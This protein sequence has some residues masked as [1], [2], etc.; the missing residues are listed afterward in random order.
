M[1]LDQHLTPRTITMITTYGCTA[2]CRQCCFESSPR[3]KGRL[4]LEEMKQ[5]ISDAK[6]SFTSL[7]VAVFSGGEATMLKADLSAAVAHA[8]Q[9]GLSTRI[10][11][12]GSWG[13][14]LSSARRKIAELAD[15][16]LKE[17]NLSTGKDHQEWVPAKSIM[18]CAVAAAEHGLFCL[19]TVEADVE[20][21]PHF[22]AV[23]E[24]PEV[25]A[26]VQARKLFIQSN[27]W[28]PFHETDDAR[29]GTVTRQTLRRG[30]SQIFDNIVV[31]PY[32][33]VS[34][35]C[36][37]TLEHIPEMKLGSINDESASEIYRRQ[38]NDFLKYWIHVDGPYKIIE[39]ILPE[40]S[41]NDLL[42]DV[43][44]IC[45]ACVILHR[46]TEVRNRLLELHRSFM[47]SVM[48]RFFLA[49]AVND[50][51]FNR[52]ASQTAMEAMQ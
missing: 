3:I 19:I 41:A 26:L 50:V 52:I 45:Q 16:G 6:H 22:R 39:K 13:R 42:K 9:E 46:S 2:E 29:G 21:S 51:G 14:T 12:N 1:S 27:S 8:T 17:L 31:T 11:S 44:H 40:Q 49:K 35:C 25:R 23:V 33:E 4:S 10:V 20:G 48:T 28:M 47:P 5:S 36:G 32:G 34:A 24:Q 7:L 30:C 18:H 37:L 15:A 38:T 43:V